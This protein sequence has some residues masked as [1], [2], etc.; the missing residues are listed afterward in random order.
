MSVG[1]SV[2]KV[3]VT[4]YLQGRRDRGQGFRRNDRGGGRGLCYL[5]ICE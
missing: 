4:F 5:N 2:I 3:T 1:Q